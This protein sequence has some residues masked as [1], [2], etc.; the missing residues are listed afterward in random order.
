MAD[1]AALLGAVAGEDRA[2]DSTALQQPVP[3][4]T[5]LLEEVRTRV[6]GCGGF[7][8]CDD[9]ENRYLCG[10]GWGVFLPGCCLPLCFWLVRSRRLLR[11][12]GVGADGKLNVG[13]LRLLGRGACR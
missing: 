9:R 11:G 5:K 6:A 10:R 3:D 12:A 8:L 1:C 7:L 2:G 4:Y 13:A